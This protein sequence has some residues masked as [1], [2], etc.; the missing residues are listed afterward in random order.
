M[1]IPSGENISVEEFNNLKKYKHLG[2][3]IESVE[4]LNSQYCSNVCS[5]RDN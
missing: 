1:I 3:E 5:T 4:H 2:S